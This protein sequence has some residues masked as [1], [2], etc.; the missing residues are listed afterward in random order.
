MFGL[1]PFS[2]VCIGLAVLVLLPTVIG[3]AKV[4]G[5]L[6]SAASWFSRPIG[7]TTTTEEKALPLDDDAD[8]KA[9]K[10]LRDRFTI[11]K[12]KDGI[13]AV[14]VATTHFWHGTGGNE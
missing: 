4:W 5:G 3:N 2:L 9:L 10:R 13:A 1:Q 14:D 8:F 7:T 11:K 6:K 12:C